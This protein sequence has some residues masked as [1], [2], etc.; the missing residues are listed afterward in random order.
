MARNR[1]SSMQI[2]INTGNHLQGD[3]SLNAWA[4]Q[5]LRDRLGR[6]GDSITRV[7]VH[8]SDVNGARLGGEDKR[9]KL[10]ARLAGRQPVVVSHDAGK[11]ADAL[12]GAVD[13]L[14]RLLDTALG[15]TRDAAGRSSVRGGEAV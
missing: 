8:L 3:E 11:V 1:R 7:E 5:E 9:C 12:F 4:E 15:R 14:Q 13:K 10:E 2:Q 6:F